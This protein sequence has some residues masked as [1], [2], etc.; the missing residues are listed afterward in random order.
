MATFT[1]NVNLLI[2]APMLQDLLIDKDGTAMSGGVITMYHDNS[3]TTLKNWYYQSGTPGNYTY[4][5]LPNPLTLSAAGT[6]CDL[7]GVDT[8]PFYYPYS[9]LDED[10]P[11]PY[12]V[13]IVNHA[14]TNQIT[15]SNFPFVPSTGSS[16]NITNTFNNLIANNVF[17]RNLA[18]NSLNVTPFTSITL[19]S[20]GSSTVLTQDAAT[21]LYSGIVA[22]S[23]HDGFR[24]P[25]IQYV[26]NNLSATDTLTFTP[27]PLSNMQ[28]IANT[29]V[30]EYYI[31]HVCTN[32]GSGV[33]T[34][35]YQFPISLHV[36]T[37]AN[38][39]FTFSFQ[40]QNAGGSGVGQNVVTIRIF[41]DTGSGTTSPAPDV[42]SQFTLTPGWQTYSISKIFPATAGLTL[43]EGADDALYLQIQMPTG[44]TSSINFTKPSIY[45]T[46]GIVPNYDLATYDQVDTIINSPRTGD[47]RTSLN[48]FLPFGWVAMNN[49]SIGNANS[50]GTARANTDAWPL[51]NLLWNSFNQYS[52]GTGASGANAVV[53]MFL[54]ATQV[55]YGPGIS[56]SGSAINDW[57][58]GKNMVL[59]PSLGRVI[60]GTA[61]V[62]SLTPAE[63]GTVTFSDAAGSLLVNN[64]DGNFTGTPIVF[65]NTGGALPTGLVSTSVYYTIPVTGTTFKLATSFNNAITGVAIAYTNSGSGTT[66]AQSWPLG[67]EIGEFDHTQTIGE[68]V[69]HN[70]SGSTDNWTTFS[71]LNGTVGA[72]RNYAVTGGNTSINIVSNGSGDPFNIIQTSV[73]YNIFIK[74]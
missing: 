73:L 12:Y 41:Q 52:T 63:R 28:P 57:N 42:I 46:S 74:L 53:R 23:Q 17:W 30:P 37:L 4:I 32:A 38:V 55:G 10:V 71:T 34:K 29:V 56:G 40:A 58:A 49:G 39:P 69:S 18:P 54:G 24:M 31:S 50:G 67:V 1:G 27:F 15:R 9:E 33:S 60:M 62:S 35:C 64:F 8:I 66:T 45:L 36:N 11:D 25:D 59:T 22:P 21:G 2:A 44:T 26:V 72:P 65:T 7:N 14:Q 6:I 51:F 48:S 19:S 16:G 70:H 5:A 43:S 3:R 61:A 13:T 47:L 20:S 68:L